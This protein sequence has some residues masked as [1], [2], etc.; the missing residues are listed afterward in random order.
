MHLRL[1]QL[2]Y[3]SFAGMG[4]RT[5]TSA[6]VS[7]EIQQAFIQRVVSR[8]WDTY[9][10]PRSGYR[11]VY[12]HQVSLEQTLF[13][14]LYNDGSDEMG[15]SHIPYCICYYLAEPLLDFQLENIFTCLRTGPVTIIE[16]HSLPASL[17]TKVLSDLGSYKPA[18]PGVAVPSKVRARSHISLQQ[19]ELLDLLIPLNEQDTVIDLSGQ[20][21]EQ[22]KANL[23]IY[24][25]YLIEGIETGAAG[26]EN[27][28]AINPGAIKLYRG[29]KG[30]GA[31]T[32]RDVTPVKVFNQAVAVHEAN[33]LTLI[34]TVLRFNIS[35]QDAY[36]NALI[37][38]KN[39]QL[40]LKV[41]ITATVLALMSSIYGLLQTSIFAPSNP[42]LT[43]YASN[44]VFYKTLAEVPNVPQGLFKYG[45]STTFAPLRATAI[46]SALKQ[47]HPQFQ[48][49]YAEPIGSSPGSAT[50][51]KMLL[52]GELNF[53]QS[54]RSVKDSELS[55]AK[56]RGFT[57]EKIP[58]AIDGIA[59]YVNSQASIPGLSLSQLR[60]IFTGKI[61]N[62]K[63]VGGPD[64]QIV[65]F[66]RNLR[67]SGTAELLKEKVLAGEEFSTT[68]QEVETTTESIRKVAT[69]PGGI[70]YATASEVIGQKT[71]HTLPLSA[72][73]P[74]PLLEEASQAFVSP[75]ADTNEARVNKTAFA[76]GS[77]PLTRQ[78][79][80][81]IKRDGTIDEQAG[82]A[83]ANLFLTDEG[84]RLV[85]KA[86][87]APIR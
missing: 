68:V 42:Q 81:I 17:E 51:I 56:T 16:R 41:G 26:N 63:S 69:I 5:F 73:H 80:V 14:W 45:G 19:G 24:T 1:G 57:L 55:F 61:T 9:N 62:W 13:G 35:S 70:G 50:G 43:S 78:I 22:H 65:P 64:L 30:A 8:H 6:Q 59:F 11:A 58:V 77:Y 47:A 79:F 7:T 72:V 18:R 44:P 2:V 84:Q 48:L 15:R 25:S 37:S 49:R 71:I 3:T 36:H 31:I 87:F 38:Y 75:F 29:N 40:L 82:T 66:S 52:A 4:F 21:Y 67:F 34:G 27:T 76:N 86:G 32:S 54:S 23:S 85:E 10:P 12:L 28:A 74:L 20:T 83:Y 33:I 46:V 60:D 53:A 39:S